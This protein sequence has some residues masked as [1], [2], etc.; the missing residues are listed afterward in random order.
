MRVEIRT[1]SDLHPQWNKTV[2]IDGQ[3][4]PK[5]VLKHAE[6]IDG[7]IVFEA[8]TKG[9]EN[10]VNPDEVPCQAKP[11]EQWMQDDRLQITR[12]FLKNED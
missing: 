7:L 2:F 6:V 12:F 8:Y 4:V 10:C 3:Q 9:M 5:Q 1:L 11:Y